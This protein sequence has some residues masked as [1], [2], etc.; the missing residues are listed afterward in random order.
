[1]RSLL[2]HKMLTPCS[3]SSHNPDACDISPTTISQPTGH[4]RVMHETHDVAPAVQRSPP[5]HCAQPATRHTYSI[6]TLDAQTC[7]RI[8][9]PCRGPPFRTQHNLT[10]CFYSTRRINPTCESASHSAVPGWTLAPNFLRNMNIC[11][12]TSAAP[13]LSWKGAPKIQHTPMAMHDALAVGPDRTKGWQNNTIK[14]NLA[15]QSAWKCPPPTCKQ[16]SHMRALMSKLSKDFRR[17]QRSASAG[18]APWG[19]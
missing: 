14:T 2:Q 15:V 9:L 12:R 6:R 18:H 3:Y 16:H 1:M 8:A 10:S 4:H 5:V 13:L 11:L 17:K 19:P 7:G